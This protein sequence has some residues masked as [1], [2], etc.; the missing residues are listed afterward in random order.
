MRHQR[1]LVVS[2]T[3]VMPMHAATTPAPRAAA[4]AQDPAV[5]E[6]SLDLDR[7]TLRLIQ[8]QLRKEGFDPGT[9]DGLF[10]PR[11]RGAIRDWQRARGAASTGY[12]NR[13]EAELLRT[14]AL[15]PPEPGASPPPQ[16]VPT[17]PAA[18]R[19]SV[20]TEV[21]HQDAARTNTEPPAA[22]ATANLQLPPEI[23]VDRHLVRAQRLLPADPAA[24]FEAMNQILALRDEHDLVLEAGFHFQY[25]RAAFAAGRTETA[26]ASLN[27]YLVAAGRAGEFYREA[28][29]LLDSAEVR[30]RREQ[31]R[32]DAER[33]RTTRWP[34]GQVFR[35]CDT[36]PEMVVMPGSRVALGRHEVTVGEYRAFASAT[37]RGALGGCYD[38]TNTYDDAISW[39]NPRV[40][41]NRP[42]SG[43]VR[44][45]ARCASLCVVAQPHDGRFVSPTH[46]AGVETG[47]CRLPS[48]LHRK[49]LCLSSRSR[50]RHLP[51][52]LVRC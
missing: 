29:E 48:R 12:L 8:Q 32:A 31:R 14:A 27:E 38:L 28:L 16:A 44:Q 35:D 43:R 39:R 19:A 1:L 21:D 42:P 33:R 37:D 5:V 49:A 51:R 11:T 22:A 23:L 24:A 18:A 25:A 52:W 20:A 6:A 41:A 40:S 50:R 9:P 2:L 34:P 45:L 36:C 15:A 10:G 4:A 47:G 46:R 13:A 3:L 26:I 30:F 7:A 17:A